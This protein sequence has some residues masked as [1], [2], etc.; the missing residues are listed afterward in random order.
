M[1]PRA[2]LPSDRAM[3][4]ALAVLAFM[5]RLPLLANADFVSYDGTYY[6]NQAQALLG[7]SLAGGAFPIG[8]PLLIAPVLAIVRDG[9]VAG[10]WVSL[11]AS[12]GSVLVFEALCRR[13]VRR[14]LA[15]LAAVVFAIT[16]LFMRASVLT[17]SESAYT[18]WVLLSLLQF[19]KRPWG[20]GLAIGMAAATR[21]EALAVAGGLG[22]VAALRFLFRRPG[23]GPRA[24]AAFLLGFGVVYGASVAA[25]S[26]AHGRVTLLS[27]AGAYRS[28]AMPWQLR[29][30]SLDYEGRERVESAFERDR[31]AF[32][33]RASY[34]EVMGEEIAGLSRQLMYLVPALGIVGV[35][36]H[37]GF[38]A[39]A[40]VPLLFIPF[41]TEARGQVRWLVPYLAPLILYAFRVVDA[42]R[43]SRARFATA[44]L[45][46]ALSLASLWIN[47]SVFAT[48]V[49]SEYES[50]RG[51]ARR[52]AGRIEPGDAI[53][54][55]KPYF[56]FYAGARYV[57]IPAAPY[58]DTV[59][60]LANEG[61]RYLAL[62]AKSVDRLRPALRP[63]VFDA[64]AVRGELRYRQIV[65]EPTGE[66]I[67]E[68][69]GTT[70][71]LSFRR[72]TRPEIGDLTPAWSPD[73]R[74]IALRRFLP[75][76]GAALVL[77]D[78]DGG[79]EREL[80]RTS[81]ER[82]PIA[83]SPDGARIVYTTLAGGH[84]D[85]VSLDV[86]S[87]ATARIAG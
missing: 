24:L 1:T 32:D 11:L 34:G 54:D 87:G 2:A 71:S 25:M 57:E 35:V 22:M 58:D 82:D 48:G 14:P 65:Q 18:F 81:R 27:R 72:L 52:F 67:Y 13:Y 83:W 39:V 86:R 37:R 78:R 3:R 36:A 84:F 47:R 49:E 55:R 19:E 76:G 31:P 59:A 5:V 4:V 43:T 60:Y 74:R 16:P 38:V 85:V 69:T 12:I 28:V 75:D 10:A 42:A 6:I 73:G 41:F 29:E 79:N 70:D 63:L 66:L 44:A 26:V 40:L 30:T 15:L 50:T 23:S 68:R 45:L 56:A 17:L 7:G 61:V 64:A 46:A 77:V 51:V 9:V 33:R 80:A 20:S 62:H 21:P 8:Y 53:A